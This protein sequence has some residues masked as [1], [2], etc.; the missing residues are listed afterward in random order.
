MYGFFC[1]DRDG[2]VDGE[3]WWG[4]RD[5]FIILLVELCMGRVYFLCCGW[6]MDEGLCG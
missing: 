4:I 5:K 2:E 6:E 1:L 3:E